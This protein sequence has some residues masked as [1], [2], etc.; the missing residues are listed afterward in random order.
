MTIERGSRLI[1]RY[2]IEDILGQ[3]G[4]GSIYRAVD[5]NLGVEVAVKENLFTSEEYA[6][7]FR[8]EAVILANLRHTN[9]PR[10]TDHF[11]IDGQGQY[12]VMDFIEG[13]DLRERIDR[14]GL[15]SDADT[16]ILGT[17]ICD[18]LS[19]L[20]SR[21]PQVVHRDIKPGN[22]KITPAG[23]V[24]LVD[25]GLAKVAQGSQVT[26]TGARAMTPG[27]SPP[28]Q[29]G[30][31]R[32]D[33]RSD[34]FSLGASLYMALTG[35]LPEDALARAMGQIDLTQIRK[36]NPKVSRRLAAVIEK[37]MELRPEQRYKTAEDFKK[38]L[39]NTRVIT[40]KKAAKETTLAPIVSGA[41]ASNNYGQSAGTSS[42]LFSAVN[43]ADQGEIS[44]GTPDI[45]HDEGP[46]DFKGSLQ[47]GKRRL[48]CWLS[49]AF[50]LIL[51]TAI[52]GGASIFQPELVNQAVNWIPNN[53]LSIPILASSNTPTTDPGILS[54]T[55]NQ[56]DTLL[57]TGMDQTGTQTPTSPTPNPASETSTATLTPTRRPQPT[58]TLTPSPTLIGGG[59]GQIAFASDLTG[60]PQIY[61]MNSDGTAPR[62]IT[63]MPEGACQP[64]WSPDGERLAFVA[65][66]GGNQEIYPGAGIFIINA[67]GSDLF[68]LPSIPGGDFDPD[69]SPDGKKIAFTSLR[70]FNRAQIYEFNLE[71]NTTRSISANTVRDSQPAWSPDGTEI[72][73]V[74]TRRGPYQIWITDQDGGEAFLLSRSGSLKDTHP[75]WSPD[76]QV[77]MFTQNELIG[78]VPRLVAMRVEEGN[79]IEN[80]VVREIIPMREASYSPDGAWIAF[81]SWPEGSNHDI[82]IMTPNGLGRQRLT[83]QDGFE[84]DAAWRP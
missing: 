27:Y 70:D 17:A 61:L 20:H 73:F 48:G 28:E 36:H 60:L 37:A 71:E 74:T 64:A 83:D 19:Y 53:I 80:R 72:A 57:V 67:D 18:A 49:G 35:A 43:Q 59:A 2:Q 41:A 77:I 45:P 62:Q 76:A 26:S 8:R 33:H 84:F 4:M 34:I 54:P 32:T 75:E 6:R 25:F 24:I 55:P 63:D 82:Y 7:Q 66:C 31:A 78:G 65:P 11:V 14:Q 22:I 47:P 46:I 10:V 44:T 16:V 50:L 5:E 23:N 40:G 81:E 51:I 15:L 69:W 42:T 13:E 9:L 79:L 39:I 29:Y 30:T 3:G 58:A 68:P 56:E 38:A 21:Q 52:V 1:N 12:L